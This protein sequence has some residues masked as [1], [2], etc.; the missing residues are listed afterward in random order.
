MKDLVRRSNLQVR[1]NG[2]EGREIAVNVRYNRDSH[3]LGMAVLKARFPTVPLRQRA[4]LAKP[5][6]PALDQMTCTKSGG[7]SRRFSIVMLLR[8]RKTFAA[9]T[10]PTVRFRPSRLAM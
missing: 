6:Y 9:G 2:L 7:Q 4:R 5:D 3:I 10:R 8:E 1:E